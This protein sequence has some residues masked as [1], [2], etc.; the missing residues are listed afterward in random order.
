MMRPIAALPLLVFTLIQGSTPPQTLAEYGALG[1][2]LTDKLI[3]VV[4]ANTEANTRL[5]DTQKRMVDIML[6][7]P[8]MLDE[9]KK[10]EELAARAAALVAAPPPLGT[11]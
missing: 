6:H 9:L 4:K 7:R 8:C 2:M 1:A 10:Q 5:F 3:E 11:L